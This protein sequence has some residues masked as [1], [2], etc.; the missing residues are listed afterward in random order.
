MKSNCIK[1]KQRCVILPIQIIKD[2]ITNINV[3]SIHV[4]D[5][6]VQELFSLCPKVGQMELNCI[7]T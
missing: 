6:T 5:F 1:S 7:K 2:H 4:L 3:E